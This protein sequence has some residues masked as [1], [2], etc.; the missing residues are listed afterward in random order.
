MECMGNGTWK[1]GANMCHSGTAVDDLQ[2]YEKLRLRHC[3]ELGTSHVNYQDPPFEMFV[4]SLLEVKRCPKT[5]WKVLVVYPRSNSW[6]KVMSS[7]LRHGRGAMVGSSP[8][9]GRRY[10]WIPIVGYV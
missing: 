9:L 4:Y 8:N 1:S 7:T 6:M 5:A 3:E 2:I 10:D